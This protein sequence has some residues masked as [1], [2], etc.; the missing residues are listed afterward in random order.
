M[1]S[2]RFSILTILFSCYLTKVVVEAETQI[3]KQTLN[4][5]KRYRIHEINQ[6]LFMSKKMTGVALKQMTSGQFYDK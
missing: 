5:L 4:Q 2:Y 6:D 1:S 3:S